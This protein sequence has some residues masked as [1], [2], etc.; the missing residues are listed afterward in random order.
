MSTVHVNYRFTGP[1]GSRV[2]RYREL[3][4]AVSDTGNARPFDGGHH[5]NHA[6]GLAPANGMYGERRDRTTP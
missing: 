5:T 6:T 3:G 4:V 1:I 2:G